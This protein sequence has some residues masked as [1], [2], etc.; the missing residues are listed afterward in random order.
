[1]MYKQAKRSEM[2][3]NM[4]DNADIDG[5]DN[6]DADDAYAAGEDVNDDVKC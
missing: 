5:D 2:S 3:K 1:M 4:D 6:D